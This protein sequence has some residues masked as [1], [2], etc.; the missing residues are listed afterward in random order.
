LTLNQMNGSMAA[1]I[2]EVHFGF[3]RTMHEFLS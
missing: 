1:L 3:N 2:D